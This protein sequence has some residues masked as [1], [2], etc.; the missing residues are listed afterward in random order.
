MTK[1]RNASLVACIVVA[2]LFFLAQGAMLGCSFSNTLESYPDSLDSLNGYA[3]GCECG[4]TIHEVVKVRASADDAEQTLRADDTDGATDLDL[5]V[6]FTGLRFTS[7]AIPRGAEIVSAHVQFTADQAF[8][9]DNTTALSV[10]ISAEATGNATSFGGN[11]VNAIAT[12][13]RT[14]ASMVWNVPPWAPVQDG[15]DQ[16]TPNLGAILQEVIDGPGWQ[17]GNAIALFFTAGA[18]RREAESFDG[19]D[20]HAPAIEVAYRVATN[21]V[22]N[23]CMPSD[24]NPNFTDDPFDFPS[25]DQLQGDCS[26][27]VETTLSNLATACEYPAPCDCTFQE[28]SRH[29]NPTCNDPCIEMPLAPGCTNF[30]PE[31]GDTTATN[32]SGDMPVCVT[33]RITVPGTGPAGAAAAFF[34][35]A[36]ECNVQGVAT[37][38]IGGE[39]KAP[40]A[41]GTVDILGSP[42]PGEECSV[43]L[44]LD[45]MLDPIEFEIRFH[46]DPRFENLTA[47][48]VSATDAGLIG[49]SGFG[50]LAADTTQSTLRGE[51]PIL[52]DFIT[53]TSAFVGANPDP[54]GLFVG[55]ENHRCAVFGN[56]VSVVDD[57]GEQKL[58]AEVNLQGGIENEPP[59]AD[60]GEDQLIE[61]ASP[62]GATIVLDGT[63]SSD[64]EDNAVVF[65]WSEDNGVGP[66]LGFG[67]VLELQ[68]AV[69]TAK[70]AVLRVID[71]YGQTDEDAT[72]VA[73]QDTTAP[74]LSLSVSPSVIGPVN[75][76]LV[77]VMVSIMTADVCDPNVEIRLVSIESNEGDLADGS[78][79][80]SPDIQGATFETDDREFLLRAERTGTGTGRIYTITYEAED[81]SGN[82]TVGMTTVLVPKS[83]S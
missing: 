56:A 39:M 14:M 20:P 75:H 18:G 37:L 77:P 70:T 9:G 35:M 45:L 47:S 26:G 76:K 72:T 21:Q 57:E 16:R 66:R 69:G 78:G 54:V 65:A 67:L 42:C 38:D 1:L 3:C 31:N 80:T 22:L 17:Q 60:A 33:D 4:D 40:G 62:D 10:T 68:L 50:M 24:L 58:L 25:D 6:V 55:W 64:P 71:A 51:R 32:V 12:R 36:S 61:C 79:H 7:L 49:P 46:S 63:G 5:G 83:Q 8:A 53:L 27:R 13:P 59:H 34:G 74:E 2:Q 19:F 41:R 44:A 43:S 48:G 11:F 73:V 30:D 82:V 28:G 81:A 23:V 29:F 52:L 15:N